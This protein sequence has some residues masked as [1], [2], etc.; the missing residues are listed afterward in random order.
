MSQAI[1]PE[2]VAPTRVRFLGRDLAP[3]ALAVCAFAATAGLSA[4]NGGFFPSSWNWSTLA[5]LWLAIIALV[6]RPLARLHSVEVA[7]VAA[8]V[9]LAGWTWLSIAWSADRTQSLLEGE[10]ILILVAAVAAVLAVAGRRPVKPL[11]GG[12]LAGIVLLS[13]YALLTRLFP[14]RIGGY[15]PLAVYR[16]STPIGYWNGLGIFA[17]MG[18]LLSLGIASHANRTAAR[19]GAAVGLLVLLPTLYFTFSR[20]SWIALGAGLVVLLALDPRRLQATVAVLAYAPAPALAVVL[21]SRSHALTHPHT[22]LGRA[23]HDGHRLAL[24]LLGLGVLQAMVALAV[25][26]AEARVRVP[27]TIRLAYGA[28]LVAIVVAGLATVFVR[29]GSPV[30]IARHGYH[31]FTAPPP[32]HVADLNERLLNF[33]GNGRWPLW[34]G[35]WREARANPLLGD[36]AGAYGQYWLQHRPTALDVEDAHGLYLETLAELGPF[37]LALLLAFLAVPLVAAVRRRSQPLVPAA[38]A[39][40]AAYAVHATVDWDW[41]LSGV[42]LAATLAGSA[43]VLAIREQAG[44]ERLR[45]G[46]AQRNVAAGLL[47]ALAVVAFVGLLGNAAAAKSESAARSGDWRAAASYAHRAIRWSPWSSVGWQQLGEAQLARHQLG[48]ARR[49][50]RKAIAKDPRNWVLWL[51]L[52]AASRGAAK[53]AALA[54]AQQLNRLSPDLAQFRAELPTR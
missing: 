27:Q 12:L 48:P 6:V 17:A 34:Q 46:R 23:A 30:S 42:T 19:I 4:A 44:G 50:L 16:L 43:C 53:R 3:P 28:A 39:A 38:A 40:F 41:E 45:V 47:L 37:G 29:Y 32:K 24:L 25:R 31:S 18:V 54:R 35:A 14:D 10:R 20:G 13:A 1:V 22:A 52:S 36:G 26:T 33:S 21:A 9:A 5:L 15:D 11:L 8:I 49:S 51:D 7:L 2:H